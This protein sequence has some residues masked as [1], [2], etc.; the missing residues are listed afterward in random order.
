[1]Y[2]LF[3]RR[4]T[5]SETDNADLKTKYKQFQSKISAESQTVLLGKVKD[6]MLLFP[7]CIL[8]L[9]FPEVTKERE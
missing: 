9:Y 2:S 1:M 3:Y 7:C 4:Y 5:V 8:D 6:V